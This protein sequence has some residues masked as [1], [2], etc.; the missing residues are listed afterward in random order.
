MSAIYLPLI[1][2]AAE[3]YFISVLRKLRKQSAAAGKCEAG[4]L[5]DGSWLEV[6][7]S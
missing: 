5:V 4:K 3:M 6:H 2:A 7:R 1:L